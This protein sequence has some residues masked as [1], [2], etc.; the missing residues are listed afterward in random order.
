MFVAVFYWVLTVFLLIIY[1]TRAY[2]RIPKVPWTLVS[3]CFYGSAFV[4][5]LIA[6]VVDATSITKEIVDHN[7]NSW[8]A[9]AV[10][11]FFCF[12]SLC[13]IK[14]CLHKMKGDGSNFCMWGSIPS[15]FHPCQFLLNHLSTGHFY[16]LH[17]QANFQFSVL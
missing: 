10:S 7:Y 16:P 5:Y 13:R 8:T 2:T 17:A 15:E 14:F 9:S 4:L 1:I 11:G 6:A 12:F 3:L